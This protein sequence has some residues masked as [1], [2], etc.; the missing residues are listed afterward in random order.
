MVS[1]Q[2]NTEIKT[3]LLDQIKGSGGRTGDFDC[4]FNPLLIHTKDR[5]LGIAQARQEGQALPLVNLTQ[6]G[7]MYFVRDGHHRIS[8]AWAW[9]QKEIEAK[10]TVWQINGL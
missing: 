10:V 3:V 7:D 4:D 6:I 8:V 2:G 5:W 9:G 1:K